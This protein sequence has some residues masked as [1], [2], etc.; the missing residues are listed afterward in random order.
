MLMVQDGGGGGGMELFDVVGERI[1]FEGEERFL[2]HANPSRPN[3][4]T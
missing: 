1:L 4:G 3:T 2:V